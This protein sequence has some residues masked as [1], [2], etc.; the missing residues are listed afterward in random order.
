[1]LLMLSVRLAAAIRYYLLAF[2][3]TNILLRH[4][5]ARSGLKWAVLAA[6]V[7][8]PTYLF[9]AAIATAVIVDGGPGW[10]NLVAVTCMWNAMKFA[11]LGVLTPIVWVEHGVRARQASAVK[12][13]V[14]R[15]CLSVT[16]SRSSWT[17]GPGLRF[18]PRFF[19]WTEKMP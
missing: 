6:L 13:R 12:S 17:G 7:L 18:R 16:A 5:R 10:L 9:A 1:M 11:W 19:E 15:P 2:A 8:V 4:L 3:P 14:G